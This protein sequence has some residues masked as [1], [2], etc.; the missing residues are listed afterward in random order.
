MRRNQGKN[1]TERLVDFAERQKWKWAG[2]NVKQQMDKKKKQLGKCDKKRGREAHSQ[3]DGVTVLYDREDLC[4]TER[5]KR[6][7][8]GGLNRKSVF[9]NR[10]TQLYSNSNRT[11]RDLAAHLMLGG[12]RSAWINCLGPNWGSNLRPLT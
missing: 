12:H 1:T 2:K 4:S 8:N 11:V 5:L 6:E 9:C 10:W 7:D 3:Q